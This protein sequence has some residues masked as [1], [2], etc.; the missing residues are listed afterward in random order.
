LGAGAVRDRGRRAAQP[1]ADG[2]V[3]RSL[4]LVGVAAVL[5]TAATLVGFRVANGDG[6]DGVRTVDITIHYSHFSASHLS[7]PAGTTVRFVIHNTDPIDHEF[8][9]GDR[10]V[11]HHIEVTEH[12]EH[13]G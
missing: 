5:G 6:R 13:D 8:I 3:R 11:Q 1:D 7:F 9:V 12:P 2:A 4:A 10:A